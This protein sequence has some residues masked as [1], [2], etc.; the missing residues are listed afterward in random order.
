MTEG[1]WLDYEARKVKKDG[2]VQRMLQNGKQFFTD[3]EKIVKDWKDL[4]ETPSGIS[5]ATVNS[6][7]VYNKVPDKKHC[8]ACMMGGL[9]L[10]IPERYFEG[11]TAKA[12]MA[13]LE[14]AASNDLYTQR[15]LQQVRQT[16][17]KAIKTADDLGF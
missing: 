11:P 17:D 3:A 8:R 5:L 10:S 14:W 6:P 1:P 16:F 13:F 2:R 9:I 7:D 12:A 4:V 15:T